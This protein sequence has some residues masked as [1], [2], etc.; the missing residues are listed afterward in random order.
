MSPASLGCF[1]SLPMALSGDGPAS[2]DQGVAGEHTTTSTLLVPLCFPNQV[3]VFKNV[4]A[5]FPGD[6]KRSWQ[7]P[8]HPG[9]ERL[10]PPYRAPPESRDADPAAPQ[11]SGCLV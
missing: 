8:P 4:R 10:S 7:S 1:P 6:A 9:T 2:R 11:Q 3:D 5:L